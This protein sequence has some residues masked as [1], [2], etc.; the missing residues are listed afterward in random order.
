VRGACDTGPERLSARAMT[1][2]APRHQWRLRERRSF[3]ICKLQKPFEA[4]KFEST[5]SAIFPRILT[6]PDQNTILSALAH[7]RLHLFRVFL[8][9][10]VSVC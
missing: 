2:N 7:R 1:G 9:L 5:L 6:R 3:R 8:S 10:H 4:R